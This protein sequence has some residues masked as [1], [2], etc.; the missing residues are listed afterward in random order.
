MFCT[1]SSD[2]VV[3]ISGYIMSLNDFPIL[4]HFSRKSSI[5][6][7]IHLGHAINTTCILLL[8][9]KLTRVLQSLNLFLKTEGVE[10]QTTPSPSVND[11]RLLVKEKLL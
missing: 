11:L 1:A 9:K 5:L 3:L 10:K 2:Q 6:K 4:A 8:L 7:F